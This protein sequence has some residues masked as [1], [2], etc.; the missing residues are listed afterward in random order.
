MNKLILG[1]C[2]FFIVLTFYVYKKDFVQENFKDSE[3]R[4]NIPLSD[5]SNKYENNPLLLLPP[6]SGGTGNTDKYDMSI[7]SSND[8]MGKNIPMIDVYINPMGKIH[9]KKSEIE[10]V[11][12]DQ[13]NKFIKKDTTKWEQKEYGTAKLMVP[14]TWKAMANQYG[15]FKQL[16]KDV[17]TIKDGLNSANV[18]MVKIEE[19]A[20]SLDGK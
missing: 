18:T 15:Q 4:L 16:I 9:F 1:I 17:E 7:Q 14:L 11:Y 20:K 10:Q 12:G 2:I 8:T 13:L 19:E 3:S 5:S 6:S